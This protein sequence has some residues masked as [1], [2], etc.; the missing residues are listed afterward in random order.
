MSANRPTRVVGDY[1]R[2]FQTQDGVHYRTE[3]Q[4]LGPAIKRVE[5]LKQA[6]AARGKTK[7]DRRFVGSVPSVIIMDWCRKNHYTLDQWARNDGGIKG[8]MYPE[9]KSGVKDQFMAFFLSRDFSKLHTQHVTTK[10]ENLVFAGV[11]DGKLR[12]TTD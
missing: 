11:G 3:S 7:T 5:I 12:G 2:G 4:D 1:R 9:S 8:L 10:R 6:E